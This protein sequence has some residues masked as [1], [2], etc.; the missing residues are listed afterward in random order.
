MSNLS[1]GIKVSEYILINKIDLDTF[2]EVWKARHYV[3][4]KKI[5][6]IRFPLSDAY[7]DF[8]KNLA[9]K[10]PT[11]TN[12]S[13][14]KP[15]GIGFDN[16][17]PHLI[18]EWYDGKDLN[19]FI[20]TDGLVPPVYAIDICIRLLVL[21]EYLNEMGFVY[22]ELKPT[23]ILI[24]KEKLTTPKGPIKYSY[25]FKLIDIGVDFSHAKQLIK[26][27]R[28]DPIHM[29]KGTNIYKSPEFF[30]QLKVDER[31]DIFSVGVILYKMLTGEFPH[32]VELPSDLNPVVTDYLDHITK[33]ALANDRDNRYSNYYELKKDLIQA[34]KRLLNS[35]VTQIIQNPLKKLASKTRDLIPVLKKITKGTIAILL[36]VGLFYLGSKLFKRS[37]NI[38]TINT[39]FLRITSIPLGCE[40]FIDN[41]S[42]GTTP[43]VIRVDKTKKTI[44]TFQNR[45]YKD[46]KLVL[47]PKSDN[48]TYYDIY[49]LETKEKLQT[50]NIMK[51]SL[52]NVKL[53][54]KK[55]WLKIDTLDVTGANIYINSE[56][57]GTSPTNHMEI[58]AGVHNIAIQKEGYQEIS[59]DYIIDS[60]VIFERSVQLLS[61][62]SPI[63][64]T[65]KLAISSKPSEAI[66]II[67]NKE[68]GKTPL[69]VQVNTGTYVISIHKEFFDSDT[70][71]IDIKK[72]HSFVFASLRRKQ[73][74]TIF[75]ITP[76]DAS[77]T[78]KSSTSDKQ[79]EIKDKT[80]VVPADEYELTAQKSGYRTLF[81]KITVSGETQIDVEMTKLN[82]SKIILRTEIPSGNVYIDDKFIT[83][84]KS[85]TTILNDITPGEHQLIYSGV[86]R[87]ITTFEN[88]ATTITFSPD[89][90]EVVEIPSGYFTY[91]SSNRD[92][93]SQEQIRVNLDK[94]YID[95]FELSNEKYTLFLEYIRKTGDHTKCIP[96]EGDKTHAPYF[97]DNAAFNERN[98]PVVGIDFYDAMAY[99]RWCGKDIP[100][101]MQWEKAA[102]GQTL[103]M[104]PWGDTKKPANTN[105]SG[106][107]DGY[108]YPAPVNSFEPGKSVYGCHNMVGN[109]SEW[110]KIG[111]DST[112]QATRGGS[113]MDSIEFCTVTTR[114][115]EDSSIKRSFVGFRTVLNINV[116]NPK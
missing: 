39:S 109:I 51:E 4:D 41:K 2:S 55:A 77:L 107:A 65:P 108:S 26:S 10:F 114:A 60:E 50:L 16:E 28:S 36:L 66:V 101:E 47:E 8:L 115:K 21:L 111:I 79:F 32:G 85:T 82:P 1:E 29:F 27:F 20:D 22:P 48:G 52:E 72:S 11:L 37:D 54:K 30:S 73:C 12:P 59:F 5:V 88:E 33:K 84:I 57:K 98:Q 78:L 116:S 81:K 38:E 89:D 43:A 90:L 56:P 49:D 17:Q 91:G 45:F 80:T 99:A 44:I 6:A 13:L 103:Y 58:E 106:V 31:S 70:Y 42:S 68:A 35:D 97:S 19:N 105:A 102:K 15:V 14:A 18:L 94:F 34:K 113:F 83:E 7:S 74:K 95:K 92:P 61:L 63:D 9:L 75:R 67:N 23:N 96:S 46:R 87:K 104:Y 110:C 3:L 69:E 100:S 86:L 62:D 64:S 40:I 24:R 76:A 71:T 112:Y 93:F 53:A 25:S